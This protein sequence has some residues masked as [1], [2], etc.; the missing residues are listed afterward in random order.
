MMLT[1]ACTTT[2]DDQ[3]SIHKGEHDTVRNALAALL[4]RQGEHVF[5]IGQ[6]P[7]HVNIFGGNAQL[8]NK[9]SD[10][11]GEAKSEEEIES[12]SKAL[13]DD[14]KEIGGKAR[15]QHTSGCLHDLC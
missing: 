5:R 7:T 8:S 14:V 13:Q 1:T 2:A 10:W 12:I 4:T 11:T 6:H 9:P 15:K 3:A